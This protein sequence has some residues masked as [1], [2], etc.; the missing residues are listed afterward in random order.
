MQ[1]EYRQLVTENVDAMR[2]REFYMRGF[3]NLGE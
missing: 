3:L 2:T 1:Y